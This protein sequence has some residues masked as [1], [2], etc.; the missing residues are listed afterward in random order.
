MQ[1]AFLLRPLVPPVPLPLVTHFNLLAHL[2]LSRE[3]ARFA[4]TAIGEGNIRFFLPVCV[5][6]N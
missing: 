2:R 4:S 5:G 1:C 3:N 6:N